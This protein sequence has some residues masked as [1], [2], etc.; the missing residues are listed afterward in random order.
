M[1]LECS[2]SIENHK[3]HAFGIFSDTQNR[4]HPGRR[5]RRQTSWHCLTLWPSGLKSTSTIGMEKRKF[6]VK[7]PR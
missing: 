6:H 7:P 2:H 1:R 5:P 4:T 3:P